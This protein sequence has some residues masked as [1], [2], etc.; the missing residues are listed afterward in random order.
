[1]S[2][3][4]K[5]TINMDPELFARLQ[6]LRGQLIQLGRAEL[7]TTE[8]MVKCIETGIPLEERRASKAL[9]VS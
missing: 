2:D 8:V 5:V 6:A 4:R 7:T 9:G 1:M 3:V